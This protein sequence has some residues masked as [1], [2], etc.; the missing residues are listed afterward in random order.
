MSWKEPLIRAHPLAC[1]DTNARFEFDDLVQKEK[2][3][4]VGNDRLDAFAAEGCLW[5]RL[6]AAEFT[7]ATLGARSAS[8]AFG[9]IEAGGL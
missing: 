6:H 2:R 7:S 9:E 1:H 3:L 4:A 8:A 5:L